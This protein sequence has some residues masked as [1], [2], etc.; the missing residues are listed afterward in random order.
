VKSKLVVVAFKMRFFDLSSS[1]SSL[2]EMK[3]PIKRK[4]SKAMI[5][6]MMKLSISFLSAEEKIVA[7]GFDDEPELEPALEPQGFEIILCIFLRENE[8]KCGTNS[9]K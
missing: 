8:E 2:N 9:Q 5:T 6:Y 1:L 3:S 7:V 4:I